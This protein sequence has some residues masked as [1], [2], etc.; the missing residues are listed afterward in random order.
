MWQAFRRSKKN[1]CSR[2]REMLSGYMDQRLNPE[3]VARSEEHLSTCQG[4]REELES[5][6]ATVALLHRLPE[7]TP[8][9]SFAVVPARPV[10]GRRALPALRF[11]TAGV[12]LLLVL[13][14]AVDQTNIVERKE[15]AGSY[16]SIASLSEGGEAYWVVQ[17]ELNTSEDPSLKAS[18]KLIVPD[19]SDNVDTAVNF[20]AAD[21]VV[22][23]AIASG[24]D[25][26]P[27][28][29][30]SEG[31][32]EIGSSEN[33]EK[34]AVV[35]ASSKTEDRFATND[36]T[37][38]SEFDDIMKGQAGSYLNILSSDNNMLY[39]FNLEDSRREVVVA[40]DNN[41]L[42]P[43]EY[44]LAGLAAVLAGVTAAAW[45]RQRRARVTEVS[46]NKN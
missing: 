1:E 14:L 41:W 23:G 25:E 5:L 29:V 34:F 15:N 7:E 17:G 35:A 3:E 45:L 27:Q 32:E 43:L 2:T 22:Y 28:L 13:A 40:Q 39:S 30:L 21:G 16:S 31:E 20:L 24:P 11:A 10:P 8:S 33:V 26:V 19:G 37:P 18:V 42:R 36:A 4:C 46:R 38:R 6:R 9:R 12:V 44:G